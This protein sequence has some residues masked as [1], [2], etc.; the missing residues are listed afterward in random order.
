MKVFDLRC[1]QG[2][3]FE[4]WFGGDPDF[5][6]QVA[7]GLLHC[8]VCGSV[9]VERLPSAP[10]LNVSNLRT[11]AA[12]PSDMQAAATN[13]AQLQAAMLQAMRRLLAETPDVG[14]RFAEEARRMHYGEA[15]QRA[16]RGRATA[17]EAKALHDE[18]IEFHL[19]PLPAALKEP[20]Q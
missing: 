2:H 5:H 4:G 6:D 8:P 12:A 11:P 9:G 1:D 3:A 15:E 20:L 19:L 13:D 17:D 18:G 16:I 10:H 7:R 14:E